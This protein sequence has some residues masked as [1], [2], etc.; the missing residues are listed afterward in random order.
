MECW[1]V[2]VVLHAG[3]ILMMNRSASLGALYS[4]HKGRIG[5]INACAGLVSMSGLGSIG[6]GLFHN[7]GMVQAPF[8]YS[9]TIVIWV[10]GAGGVLLF[11]LMLLYFRRKLPPRYQRMLKE[12]TQ[13]GGT[14]HD[15]MG[16]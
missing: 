6:G 15:P 16:A 4:H 14:N 7:I 5:V 1:F 13:S 10:I 12:K 9:Q 2:Q 8:S 11:L 3:D